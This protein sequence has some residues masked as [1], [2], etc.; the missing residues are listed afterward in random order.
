LNLQGDSLDASLTVKNLEAS[1]TWYTTILG[2]MVDRRHERGGKLIAVSLKAGAVRI[3]LTQDD[4][5]KGLDRAKGEGFSL[6][7]TTRQN[8]DELA[9]GI[10]A[11]GVT[12]DTEPVTAPHGPRIFRVRDPDGFRF[13]ISSTQASGS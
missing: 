8:A 10:K 1:T 4:G 12:L 13:T 2:F 7:I 3:L 5:S 6:Q 9:A 11:Q